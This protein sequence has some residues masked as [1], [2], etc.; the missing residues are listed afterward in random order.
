MSDVYMEL[1]NEKVQQLA[2]SIYQE[3][4]R[5]INR[6]DEDV[7]KNLMPLLVN[8]LECLDASYRINQEQDVE[9]E[10][11]R[12]DNEQLVT[13][14]ER[15][16]SARKQSEQKLLEAEDLAEQENKEL[17]SR[18]ESLESIVRMLELKHKNSVEHASRLEEREAD[19]K[20]EY[21]RL[22]ERYTELFKNH[23]DYMERTKMLMG[24]THSQMSNASDRMEVSRARL[25]PVARSSGP[26]SYGFASLENSVMLD[27]ETIC[28]VGSQSD[29]SGPPSL[30][31]E[32]DNLAGTVE[33][34]AATDALQQQHQATSPQSP[35][36]SPVVPNVPANVG[37]STTKKEQR[38]DNNLYQELSFQ[39]NEESEENEI[40][41]GSWVHPGEYAS[42]ANDNYFGMGKEVENL[43]MEN[44]ELLATK[45]ALNIVKDDLIVKVDELTGEVEIVREELNAMQQS[46]TKLRQRIGELEDELKKTKEQVKQQS[47]EQEENDVPLAQRKRFTR[48]E[49][50]MV[51]MER[52]QYKE[53]L[54]ELQ[55]AV[56]L[57][58]ILRASRTVDNLDKKSKQGIWQ[59]FSNLFTHSNRS[60]E[61][62]A[63]GLGG[64]PMFRHTGGG[65]PAHSHGSPSR[66]GSD[67]RLA[68][69][70]S[71][72]PPH[73][74]S[75]GLANALIMAK[76]YS[77]EGSSERI[78]ARRRE[79]YRQ[80]RAH[81]Q[82]EDGR[83]HAYGW[84]LPINKTNQD[85]NPSRHSGGVPVPVYCNPLAE[86]SPHMKVFCAAGVNLQG[87][88][89]KD[90]QSLIPPDSPYAPRSTLKIAE[91]SSPT[92]EHSAEALDRQMARASLETLEPET[93]LS[94]FVWICTST[95]AASTVSVVDANQSATVLD[96]FPI[97]ASH[98]LCIASVQ[99][100]ME[101]DYALLEQS[102][103]VKAGEMLQ[104]P[105]EGTELLGKVEFVRVKPKSD[106]NSNSK[107]NSLEEEV[108]A[109][110]T[111]VGVAVAKEAT[112]KSNEQLPAVDATEPLANVEAIK[113]RQALPGAPQR[114]PSSS[115]NNSHNHVNNNNSSNN[116][117]FSIKSLNPILGTKEREEPAM[118]SVGPTMWLGAQDGWLYVHS[119]VGRWHEC[120]H[121][122]LL[123][124]AVLAIVHV[125]ARVV[126]ALANAQ[127]AVFRRQTDGQWDLN[128]YH[129]VTVGDRNHSIR[130]LCVAGERIWAAHRNKIFIVDPISLNIVHSLDAHPRKESQ[131]R[132]M[133]ATGAGV[134]VSIRLD[135]TLRLY[136]THT[137]EHKQD[138]DI[139]PYVSKMLG[140]GK[141]GFSF[142]RI[143]ALMVSC[144]RLWIGTSNGVIISVP[145][146]E[147][148]QKSSDPHGHMPLCCMANAQLSFHGHRDAVKF[149]VSV[150]ML[151]QPNGTLTFSNKRPDMLVMCGG[152]GYID[153]RIND[154]DMEN[155]I[156][157]EPNQTI[158]NRG[159]KSYLIV[160]HVSQR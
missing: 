145:L 149:F 99:G 66:G 25:N 39:D 34:G 72:P 26:V 123:P 23:V 93:Q 45:N 53:R 119:S 70:G 62:G 155:S 8:V 146:A 126:V 1:W 42:S 50:A 47:T 10:L 84:S 109:P 18:L 91:I 63:D 135:S 24:S 132:Q 106:Q 65:S 3:F 28:S 95:H 5:M 54:M 110:I 105:G 59:Y 67:N 86:A 133:A 137:F 40:V 92:A 41:T 75:A 113:I 127:L 77:E 43:I 78:N 142:V 122:V 6:Y 154:N 33:R 129:L 29:D 14:Y 35:D 9:V 83:L 112:E 140:T 44:N 32:L 125:E 153:F 12:E 143:T 156:Q 76:D 61:R 97:C 52:N 85:A 68:I 152:E 69:A 49:M 96:A 80:L 21:A 157:L 141:L 56:R 124:D 4:E 94:S 22:H 58:E 81:V 57:T 151:Q 74:A 88:F 160:W 115:D 17:A 147:M 11:L 117:Q 16:K 48:V 73:P 128:S 79:Q 30:Q 31:N 15:E 158:E 144:N 134:W 38:S 130:C 27:T 46:R 159:D 37:R 89:T 2:G 120:L 107:Q 104:R 148:Q 136:N 111:V 116:V 55:E 100:A 139:E 118:S 82:K 121:K 87:G 64:G 138:V 131:V 19:L 101:S 60:S 102:E 98:L 114:L 108:P 7:V 90:G 51:L 36:M 71:Q 150:P 103:V 13:Q 20:K